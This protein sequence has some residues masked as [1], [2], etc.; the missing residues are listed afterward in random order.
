M[1]EL[2]MKQLLFFI[3]GCF[4]ENVAVV[5]SLEGQKIVFQLHHPRI[6][7]NIKLKIGRYF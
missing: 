5:H 6:I 7:S 4:S 1:E 3:P 2:L